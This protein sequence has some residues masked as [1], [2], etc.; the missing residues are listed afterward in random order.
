M[1]IHKRSLAGMAVTALLLVTMAS[2]SA[3]GGDDNG[4]NGGEAEGPE[5][6]A[7][8]VCETLGDRFNELSDMMQGADF[9]D[10]DQMRDAISDARPIFDDLADDLD[11]IKAPSDI[12]EWHNSL[13]TTLSQASEVFGKLEDVLD[14]P[15]EEALAAME[16]LAPELE[17][18]EEPFEGVAD[19]PQEYRDAFEN[20]PAC[21]DLDILEE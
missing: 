4:G 9:E 2:M 16:E 14:K 21:Q 7:K 11:G 15:L 17:A 20:E 13:V 3:C 6:Y 1:R 12:Q 8:L 5:E 19:L 10:P 18:M